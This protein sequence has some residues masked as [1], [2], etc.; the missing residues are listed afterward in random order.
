MSSSAEQNVGAVISLTA[1]EEGDNVWKAEQLDI[2]RNLPPG[3]IAGRVPIEWSF[4][5]IKITGYVD[6]NTFEIGVSI[7]IVGI[8]VGNIF[9][10]LKDGV[11]LDINLFVA[12]GSI[13]LY[14]KNGNELWVH[15]DVSVTFDGSFSGDY[16]IISF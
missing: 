13:R 10:N 8:N 6:T 5:P 3:D 15:L 11:G 4:G 16:K 9:G 2:V 14:L 7:S 1:P 12:K